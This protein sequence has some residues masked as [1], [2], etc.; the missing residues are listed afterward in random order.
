MPIPTG[1]RNQCRAKAQFGPQPLH[2]R[3]AIEQQLVVVL[4]PCHETCER[5][6]RPTDFSPQ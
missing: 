6:W 5:S 4:G 3:V 2:R 1:H